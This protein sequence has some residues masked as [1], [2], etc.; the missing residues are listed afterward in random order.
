M[1]QLYRHF[2]NNLASTGN[3]NRCTVVSVSQTCVN[4]WRE[5]GTRTF[6]TPER[7]GGGQ[8][9]RGSAPQEPQRRAAL[10]VWE[11]SDRVIIREGSHQW[12]EGRSDGAVCIATGAQHIVFQDHF[13]ETIG[14]V[15]LPKPQS[16]CHSPPQHP[17]PSHPHSPPA[18]F[19][20]N[21]N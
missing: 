15:F 2:V 4:S 1:V 21:K 3:W 14:F 5:C 11:D 17:L 18:F 6:P 19:W 20:R 16:P 9:A 8:R 13:S 10:R 7:G 12:G